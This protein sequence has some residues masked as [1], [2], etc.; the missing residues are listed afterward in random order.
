MNSALQCLSHI[1]PFVQII[2]NLE[3]QQSYQLP[4]IVSAYRRLLIE[5]QSIPT[6]VTSAYE[7]KVCISELNRRFAGISQQDSHEFLTLL[8]E[9]LHDE[10][11]DNYHNSSIGDLMHGTIRSTV[12]CPICKT[13]TKT[14]DSFL[15]LPLPVHQAPS[16]NVGN[17]LITKI[18][19]KLIS[20]LR[21]VLQNDTTLYDCIDDF[22]KTEQL[23]ANGRWFCE[24]C[25]KDTDAI[26]KLD[27]YELSQVLILQLKRFTDDLTDETKISTK[28][29]IPEVLELKQFIENNEIN[30][31]VTYDLIAVMTHTGTLASGHCT[32]F[33]RH[34]T[35]RRWYHFNDEH[36]RQASSREVL[37]SHAYILVYERQYLCPSS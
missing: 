13:E 6:G 31:S 17:D 2:L 4:S 30:Q 3:E 24:K 22:L 19:D 32:A 8:I 36:V 27:L 11:M 29:E 37:T 25:Q 15:S 1:G 28:I 7:L 9:S 20:P 35:N 14:D 5:M 34:L 33:A 10:L 21:H 18:S 12:K 23:G 16:E 26:K